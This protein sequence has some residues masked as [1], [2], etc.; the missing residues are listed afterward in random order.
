MAART[1]IGSD[2]TE[3]VTLNFGEELE[4]KKTLRHPVAVFFHLCFRVLAL[5]TYPLCGWF[6]DSFVVNFVVIVFLLSMDFW[7]VKNVTGRLLVGLRW[8]NQVDE[9]GTSKWIFENRKASSSSYVE[10]Q[11]FWLSQVVSVILWVVFLL[12]ALLRWNFTWLM[13]A[14]VGITMTA[15][16]LYG[17]IRCKIGAGANMSSAATSFLGKQVLQ[18]MFTSQTPNDPTSTS[19]Q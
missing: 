16:N 12:G 3:D 11:I 9:D 10:S 17:Y 19:Y 6:S 7:T 8:W 18:S 4:E 13:V 1:M 15:S 5:I 2:E 14:G